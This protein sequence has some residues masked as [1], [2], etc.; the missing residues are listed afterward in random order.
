MPGL[1]LKFVQQTLLVKRRTEAAT[2]SPRPT[3]AALVVA[4]VRFNVS[5]PVSGAKGQIAGAAKWTEL[6][7]R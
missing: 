6:N 3:S 5:W 1:L 4:A 7:G 2:R